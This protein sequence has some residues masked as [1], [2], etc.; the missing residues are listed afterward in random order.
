MV[1][2]VHFVAADVSTPNGCNAVAKAAAERLGG[3]DIVVHVVV[4][5]SA[6]NLA[7]C[8]KCGTAIY[9][10]P[11]DANSKYFGLCAGTL[12]QFRELAPTFATWRQSSLP[13]IHEIKDLPWH[14]TE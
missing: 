8:P 7:F 6:P 12:R 2:T 14:D 11:A 5:A 1:E 4:G 3:I 9:S 10:G 13:W